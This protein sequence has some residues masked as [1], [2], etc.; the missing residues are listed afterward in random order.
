M[1][2]IKN[3]L[4]RVSVVAV[5]CLAY[6]LKLIPGLICVLTIVVCNVFL[7]KQD[8]I[9]KQ[10]LAK[11]NDVVLYMEQMIYSFKKQ[12]KIRMAL[13]DAQ[14]VSSIEMREVI[15][16]A[17]V[18]IDSNKSA[19]IYE[20]ALA[21]IEKEYNCGRIKSL[22]KF[23]IKIENYGGNYETY[24]DI[25]LEDI[26]NWSD[27]TLTFIRN[28]DRTRRNVLI[29]IASTLI[30]CGFMAY[31]IPKDYKFTEH[32]LYQVC[33]MILIM[34]MIFTYLAITKR[35]NFD[36]LKEERALPDN[37]VIKYYALVE[38]GYNNISD[39]SFMERINYKKAKKRLEREIYKIFPDWIRDVAML[40]VHRDAIE[41]ENGSRM[42]PVCTVNGQQAAQVMIICG[43]DNGSSISLPNYRQNLRFAAAW[44][45]AMEGTFPGLTRPVLFSYRFY[46]QDLTTGSLL[47][48]VGGHG[49]NLNEALYAGQLAA[50]GLIR[51]LQ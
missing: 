45:R 36:W 15:E 28:V 49:N 25:L 47:I 3:L 38:K 22:H 34:A 33:S 27:R 10:Y 41:T 7:E 20:D 44:E 6:R 43:C 5:I 12:P 4:K 50:E 18:N 32:G 13:L 9:K 48:E 11:Y 35:L 37:M 14:K 51:A 19:N 1:K 31:L 42:A 29:S 17:I 2:N 23:I 16:E 21:I 30:T 40:D 26:K 46:N 39:L 8:R 24:I